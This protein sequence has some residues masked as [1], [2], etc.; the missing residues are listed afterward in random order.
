MSSIEDSKIISPG[1]RVRIVPEV[2]QEGYNLSGCKGTV[3]DIS[4]YILVEIRVQDIRGHWDTK[5]FKFHKW[6]VDLCSADDLFSHL[7]EIDY[8]HG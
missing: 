1:D 3:T 8:K 5:I 4:S 2:Y 7:Q 6:E